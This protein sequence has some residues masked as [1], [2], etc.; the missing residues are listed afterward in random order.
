MA[1]R[2]VGLLRSDVR[3]VAPAAT[4]TFK[5]SV[6]DELASTVEHLLSTRYAVERLAEEAPAKRV[7]QTVTSE[8]LLAELA[9][10]RQ[11]RGNEPA[12]RVAEP[13]PSRRSGSPLVRLV[14]FGG[15]GI[16]LLVFACMSPFRDYV[17]SPVRDQVD[18]VLARFGVR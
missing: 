6:A 10:A 16:V 7:V 4:E 9:E 11:A 1:R 14:A 12:S 13:E 8:S 15:I 2:Q 3:S 5:A 17:P 18:V